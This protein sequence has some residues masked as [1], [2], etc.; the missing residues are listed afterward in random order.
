MSPSDLLLNV[1]NSSLDLL[2]AAIASH[3]QLN[4]DITEEEI[5][6]KELSETQEVQ[7]HGKR[8]HD[9]DELNITAPKRAGRKPLDETKTMESINNDPKQKRKAQNR[10]A[11]RAFRERKEKHVSEL[12][13]RIDELEKLN[14]TKDE[15]LVKENEH[16]KEMLRQLQ[17]ENYALKGAQFT[18]EF[19]LSDNGNNTQLSPF[20]NSGSSIASPVEQH[21]PY[22]PTSY[23]SATGEDVSSSSE[24]SPTSNSLTN[25]D[26]SPSIDTPAVTFSTD[27]LQFGLIP[28]ANDAN[29]TATTTIKNSTDHLNFFAP[30][31][32]SNN[33]NNNNN[34]FSDA[35]TNA[36]N[37][38]PA[39]DLFHGKDDLFSNYREPINVGDDFLFANEDLSNLFAGDNDFFGLNYDNH[40]SVL[41]ATSSIPNDLFSINA[42]FGL[43]ETPAITRMKPLPF[44]KKLEMY[45]RVRKAKEEGKRV[46]DLHQ[47]LR[48]EMPEFDLDALCDDLRDKA[49]CSLSNQ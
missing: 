12:Q 1:N 35:N 40:N 46:Y 41:P 32:N 48:Q 33:N 6:D 9:T 4:G 38:L 44:E 14:E 25:E 16:L 49:K 29:T 8:V 11:Q 34:S 5:F 2:N 20:T 47:E 39:G 27:M 43:P 10:A 36:T 24:Q 15:A 45:E 13:A 31:Q 3:H 21:H 26:D 7:V 22:G 28:S 18:F 23:S 42:Q 30:T 17:E 37:Q 19:P